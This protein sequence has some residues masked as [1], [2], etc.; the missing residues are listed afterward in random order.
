MIQILLIFF[1]NVVHEPPQVPILG[2]LIMFALFEQR[3]LIGLN[4][5]SEESIQ[6]VQTQRFELLKSLKKN[7]KVPEFMLNLSSYC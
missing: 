4:V 6:N 2:I 5:G 1:L 3:V 7:L